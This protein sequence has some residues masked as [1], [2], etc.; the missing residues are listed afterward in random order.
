MRDA[1]KPPETTWLAAAVCSASDLPGWV[2]FA[3]AGTLTQRYRSELSGRSTYTAASNSMRKRM[4]RFK[5]LQKRWISL[6]APV[7]GV[8]AAQ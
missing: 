6:T 7:S 1:S 4:L 2:S 8:C 5:L 3:L